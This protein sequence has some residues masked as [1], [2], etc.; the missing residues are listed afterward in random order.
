ME[1]LLNK[2]IERISELE[3]ALEREQEWRPFKDKPYISQKD[4]EELACVSI[5]KRISDDEAKN[6]LYN[7]YGFAQEKIIIIHSVSEREINRHG[8]V[9][10]VCERDRSPL[11]HSKDWNYI[12]FYCACIEYELRDGKL[13]IIDGTNNLFTSEEKGA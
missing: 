8:K 3:K 13:K 1:K 12:Y 4:Y 6:F 11:Y 10:N 7:E 5:I 2:Y 9:R